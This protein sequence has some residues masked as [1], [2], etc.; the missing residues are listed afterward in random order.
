MRPWFGLPDS[1]GH[2]PLRIPGAFPNRN[3]MKKTQPAEAGVLETKIPKVVTRKVI[4]AQNCV[5][6]P[7]S[8][9]SAH[10]HR[11]AYVVPNDR[12][13]TRHGTP[14]PSPA[15]NPG[16]SVPPPKPK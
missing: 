2:E 8:A 11:A 14:E 12:N 10:I 4:D 5:R 15:A 1:H 3:A 9:T 13:T 7:G 16:G 6:T